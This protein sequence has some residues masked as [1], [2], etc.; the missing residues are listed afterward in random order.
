MR[1]LTDRRKHGSLH[2]LRVIVCCMIADMVL[3]KQALVIG[4]KI[5]F[6]PKEADARDAVLRVF[7]E[8]LTEKAVSSP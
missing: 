4:E 3:M 8:L 1:S 5:G 2:T 6:D 7:T